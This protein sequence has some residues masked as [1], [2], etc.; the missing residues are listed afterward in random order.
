[1][2]REFLEQVDE[3]GQVGR[4]VGNGSNIRALR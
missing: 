2:R 4:E 3:Q 1:M